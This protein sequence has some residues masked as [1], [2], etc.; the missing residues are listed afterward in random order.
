MSVMI[1]MGDSKL[2]YR[3][4]TFSAPDEIVAASREGFGLNLDD[5][6]FR[7]VDW[8]DFGDAERSHSDAERRD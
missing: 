8:R 5:F 4:N 3:Y 1:T 2:P 6:D 7:E